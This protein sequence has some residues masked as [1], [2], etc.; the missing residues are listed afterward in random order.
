M[1]SFLDI[2]SSLNRRLLHRVPDNL[3]Y[4]A[5]WNGVA[6]RTDVSNSSFLHFLFSKNNVLYLHA[7]YAKNYC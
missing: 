6:M 7:G 1:Y 4:T 2:D 5:T 3:Q